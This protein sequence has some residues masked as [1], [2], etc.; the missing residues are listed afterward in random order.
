MHKGFGQLTKEI[1]EKGEFGGANR[2]DPAATA[3]TVRVRESK[4]VADGPFA[5]TTR[6]LAAIIWWRP[7]LRTKPSRRGFLPRAMVLSMC[8]PLLSQSSHPGRKTSDKVG[9]HLDHWAMM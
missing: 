2:L 4:R 3:S 5:K 1:M 6:Q 8:G 7:T 9:N